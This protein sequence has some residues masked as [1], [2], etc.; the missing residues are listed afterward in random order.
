MPDLLPRGSDVRRIRRVYDRLAPVYPL[1]ARLTESRAI[2]R[3]C[4]VA[5]TAPGDR[6]LDVGTGTGAV[7]DR[8]GPP[9]SAGRRVGLDLSPG[10]LSTAQANLPGDPWHGLIRG[11]A[12][13]LPLADDAFDVVTSAYLFDLLP[14]EGFESVLG[15]IARVS[16]ADATVAIAVM[17]FPE[18]WYERGWAAIARYVPGLLAQC[19]PVDLEPVL[20]SSG[21]ELV[22]GAHVS[23]GTFPSQVLVARAPQG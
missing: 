6:V 2:E 22:E 18:R 7:L 20:R 5:R 14:E 9:S 8:I 21:F 4:Q 11:S 3:V 13:Q 23:Q 1:W 19:R 17:G 15:E 10:M 16:V 12:D